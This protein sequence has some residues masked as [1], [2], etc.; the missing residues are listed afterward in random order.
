MGGHVRSQ[1]IER[2]PRLF[3]VA[4]RI[5]AE[6]DPRH[7]VPVGTPS[8]GIEQ[9]EICDGVLLIINGEVWTGWALQLA[10]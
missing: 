9:A 2:P 3:G 8:I 6:H 4:L 1:A 7:L 5:D 10:P